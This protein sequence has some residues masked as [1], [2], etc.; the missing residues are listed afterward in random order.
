MVLTLK[1]ISKL[2]FTC[3]YIILLLCTGL[4]LI[5]IV[6]LIVAVAIVVVI[7][8]YDELHAILLVK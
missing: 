8:P 1:M 7:V 4:L 5:I 2:P 6:I 3:I